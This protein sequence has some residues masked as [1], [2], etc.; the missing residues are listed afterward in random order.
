MADLEYLHGVE[1]VESD[2]GFRPI[3]TVKS[4]VIGL[5]GTAPLA[6]TVA[7]PINEPV[8]VNGDFSKAALLGAD[9]TLKDALDGIFDQIGASVVVI[10]VTEG[11]DQNATWTNLVGDFA[12]KTGVH[13]LLKAQNKVKITP[14]ILVVPGYTSTRPTDGVASIAVNDGGADY[15]DAP[16]VTITGDGQGATAIANIA[17]GA[18]ESVTVT[19]AG[20]GYTTATITF[21]S[22]VATATATLDAAANP[23]TA[24]LIGVADKLRAFC[25]VDGPNTTNADAIAYR[26]DF[27]SRRIEVIDPYLDAWNRITNSYAVQP[28]AA[29]RAGLQ[30]KIDNERGFWW[31][32][33]NQPINGVGGAARDI[34]WDINDPNTDANYLNENHVTTI[35][36][37]DG[38]RFWG[39]RTCSADPKWA[40]GSVVRTTDIIHESLIRSFMW[41]N[42]RP[43]SPELILESIDALNDYLQLLVN[44]GALLGGKAW[45]DP[46]L[47]TKTQ[48]MSGILRIEF[49]HEPPAP[50]E[51][52]ILGSHREPIYYE[53]MIDRVIR[54]ARAQSSA[55]AA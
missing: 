6:D 17:A 24:E 44:L 12:T 18:V 7:F 25:Y 9:G 23:V 15:V 43:I 41:A 28:S 39:L 2:D 8:L 29:R 46:N 49:D 27:G 34:Y 53:I 42:D 45:I 55:I 20:Y 37:Q 54:E 4:S 14:K 3:R 48:L 51:H 32:A 47:N 5:V 40:F 33:S 22:G 50:L 52:L 26:Q 31:S 1:V 19:N 11:V 10:R 36:H 21:D 13:A 16:I 35:I 38:Y 30:A